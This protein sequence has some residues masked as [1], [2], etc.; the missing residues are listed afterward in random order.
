MLSL[1]LLG[2][3]VTSEKI[4]IWKQSTK[5][6]AKIRA[7]LRDTGQAMEVRIEAAQA[8]A[9]M[10]LTQP[11][12][13]DLASLSGPDRKLVTEALNQ[14]LLAKMKGANPNET[15]RVQVQAKDALYSIRLL[16]CD[17]PL[18]ALLCTLEVDGLLRRGVSPK[19]PEHA[20]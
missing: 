14:G 7:A 2:C 15:P 16:L 11:L 13:T 6:A 5:G 1:A 20:L 4:N 10:G 12:T 9:E 8:L 17:Q 19:I 3:E 18:E